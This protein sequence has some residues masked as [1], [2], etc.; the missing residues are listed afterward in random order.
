MPR[1]ALP[2]K[3]VL[4]I[5]T[6]SRN[7]TISKIRKRERGEDRI[8]NQRLLGSLLVGTLNKFCKEEKAVAPTADVQV[9]KQMEV[10]TRLE[11]SKNEEREQRMKERQERMAKEREQEQKFHEERR[12]RAI[13]INA[14]EKEQHF[15]RLQNFIQTQAKP[16]IFYLP[17]KHTLRTLELLNQSSKNI[18][19]LIEK[20]RE[21]YDIDN[22]KAERTEDTKMDEDKVEDGN[23]EEKKSEDGNEEERSKSRSSKDAEESAMNAE[24]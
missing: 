1:P 16:P 2:S 9:Q 4:P 20:C 15:K 21:E 19:A 8:R 3:V 10:E 17:A 24:V 14:K 18:E 5:E 6:H 11:Q 22:E 7:E 13:Q 23:T 12:K